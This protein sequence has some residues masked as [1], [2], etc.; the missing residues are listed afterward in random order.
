MR[1]NK[2]IASSGVASRRKA[3]ELIKAG[4]VKV[5]GA[6]L[7]EP[8]YDV[9]PGDIVLVEGKKISLSEKKIYI[10]LN[11]PVGFVTTARDEQGRPTVLDLLTDIEER[12]F[13]VGRLDYNTSG[14]LILT[15]DGDFSQMISHPG[16]GIGKTYRAKVQGIISREKLARL[17]RGVDIGGFVT[18]RAQAEIYKELPKQTVVDITIYE[19]KNRQVRKMFKAIGNPVLELE[20]IAIGEVKLGRLA[21]GNYRKLTAKEIESL[22]MA[23]KT[24][25]ASKAK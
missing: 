6:I 22:K 13:P 20:R 1:I 18:S 2:Y 9:L 14:L 12:V 3:D 5:N 4:K 23:S 25:K 15:N 11:K 17:R 7:D 16:R 21:R 19:G 24:N 10:A 8:G